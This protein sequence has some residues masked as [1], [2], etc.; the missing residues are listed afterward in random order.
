[1][2]QDDLQIGIFGRSRW[3]GGRYRVLERRV[4]A[5]PEQAG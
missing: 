1:M 5:V 3:R 2:A 4:L